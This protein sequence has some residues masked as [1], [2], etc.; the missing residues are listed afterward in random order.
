MAD[1]S[2]TRFVDAPGTPLLGSLLP[3]S[4]N[5]LAHFT[6][7]LTQHGDRVRLRLPGRNVLLLA[8]P[9]DLEQVLV[10]DREAY[11]RSAELRKLRPI[12]GDGLLSSEGELWRRQRSLLQPSFQHDALLQYAALMLRTLQEHIDSWQ[13]VQH[14]DLH[15]DMMRYTREVICAVLFGERF[16]TEHTGVA[17]AVTTVFTGLRSELLYLPLWRRLPLRRSRAWNQAVALLNRSVAQQ[18]A[19]RRSS[20]H[21]HPDLLGALLRARGPAGEAMSD[22]QIHD[23][24]LTFFLAGH[25]TAALTLTWT[26]ALLA[27]HP[28]AQERIREEVTALTGGTR[29]LSPADYPRLR[30]SAAVI[31]ES[32]RLYPPVW[33]MGREATR[34]TVLG[35][36]PIAPGTDVWLCIH[37]LHRDPRWF[38]QPEAFLPERWIDQPAP[39][40]YTYVP[41]GIG[42]R[43]CI[44]QH[45]ATMETVLGIASMLSRFT[46][47]PV[48]PLPAEPSA[49]I[50]LRPR[51][52]ILL[53]VRAVPRPG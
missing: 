20:G 38:A 30:W 7:L 40:P 31:K 2:P 34:Q 47:H 3:I 15:A 5:A 41:F 26:T 48:S 19:E 11:G 42:P 28:E 14:R 6:A 51:R 50:T 8:H 37:K 18:V 52:P 9:E 53:E 49:W 4:R 25:E 35:G 43:V 44:G 12:F 36:E 24:I 16:L 22:A 1:S 39:R 10:R 23:E 46:L 17:E 33:S 27:Q 32:L 45:F 29:P 21:D 13:P